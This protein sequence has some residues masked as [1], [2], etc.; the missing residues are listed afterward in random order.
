MGANIVTAL[1]NRNNSI[2]N[3]MCGYAKFVLTNAYV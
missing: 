3:M 1:Q 2:K